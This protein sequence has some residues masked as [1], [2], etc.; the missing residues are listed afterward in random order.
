MRTERAPTTALSGKNISEDSL[1]TSTAILAVPYAVFQPDSPYDVFQPD[2]PDDPGSLSAVSKG[3]RE[4]EPIDNAM[5]P[6]EAASALVSLVRGWIVASFFM[7]STG[8]AGVVGGLFFGIA[9]GEGFLRRLCMVE[10]RM[11]ECGTPP[12]LSARRLSAT[13]NRHLR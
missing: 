8:D 11:T 9:D 7:N 3:S 5:T 13:G 12:S 2:S 6:D 1:A 4:G 10:E